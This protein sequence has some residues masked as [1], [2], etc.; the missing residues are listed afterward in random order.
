MNKLIEYTF[1][2]RHERFDRLRE[3][4]FDRYFNLLDLSV[5]ESRSIARTL[6]YAAY[7]HGC[8]MIERDRDRRQWRYLHRSAKYGNDLQLTT[9]DEHGPVSD[10]RI[11]DASDFSYLMGGTIVVYA[12]EMG[13]MNDNLYPQ[14]RMV[15]EMPLD[16]WDRERGY[17]HCTGW[18]EMDEDGIWWYE[19]EDPRTGETFLAK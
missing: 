15:K 12:K 4:D 5:S 10:A 7:L 1:T 16:H 11:R 18:E 3:K 8:V 14:R 6:M 9:W 2:D 19:F 13:N 17:S